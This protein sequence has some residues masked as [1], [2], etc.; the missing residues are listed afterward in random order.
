M[1]ALILSKQEQI[2]TQDNV[3]EYN[4]IKEKV[5][6][7]IL[8]DLHRLGWTIN[9]PDNKKNYIDVVPPTN[10]DKLTIQHSM[11]IK[12]QEIIFQHRVWIDKNIDFAQAN[13]AH[14]FDVLNSKIQPI[15]EVCKT[16]KQ[17]DLFR[18]LRFYWSSPYSEYVG[19][20]IKLIIRDYGLLN[21]L[22]N[23]NTKSLKN[24]QLSEK[25]LTTYWHKR[26]FKQRLNHSDTLKIIKNFCAKDFFIKK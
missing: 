6:A 2:A 26:R 3:V 11:G 14:G 4:S 12:R 8:R 21:K 17:H 7:L 10:Y 9:Y 15:I 24:Y 16:Q 19:R 13:L 1:N 5:H 22:V 20:R 23:G 18:I 25:K